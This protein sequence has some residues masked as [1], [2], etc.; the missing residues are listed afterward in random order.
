MRLTKVQADAIRTAPADVFGDDAEVWLF[1]SR[2]DDQ[3][4]GGDIDL[5]VRPGRNALD[6]PFHRRVR[7]LARLERSLGERKIDVVV[8]APLDDRPIVRVARA[9]GVRL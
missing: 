5:L 1:G 7:F 2:A 4:R 3:R 6:Q 8:E 9:T